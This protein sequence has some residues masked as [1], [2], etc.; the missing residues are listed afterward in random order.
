MPGRYQSP[1]LEDVAIRDSFWLPRLKT[2]YLVSLDHQ[3]DHL[4]ANGSLDNFRRVVGEAGGDFEGAPFIDANVYKWVEAASYALA[5]DE[6]P[7]LKTKVDNVLSLIEQAQADDGYLFT[8]FMLGDNSGRWS[9]FTMMHE[10]YCAGHLIEAAVAHHRALDDDR[11]LRVA[12]DL[13]DHIDERFG[14]D[15]LDKIPGH[16]EIELALVR[17]YRVTDEERYLHL[18]GYFID[19]RGRDPSPM[20][21]ELPELEQL[22]DRDSFSE[23]QKESGWSV[24]G[25]QD[26]LR[27]ESGAYDGLW[28][29]DHRPVRDQRRV[30]GHAVRAGNLYAA[31]A[32]YLQEV[33]DEDLFDAV[34]RL[35]QNMVTRRMYVTGGIGS[36]K[37]GERFTTDYDLPNDDAFAETC[38]SASAIFWSQNMFELT[39]E[40]KY[41]DVLERILYNALLSGVS[42]DGTRYCYSNPLQTDDEYHRNE[43]FYVA[44]CPPNLSRVLASLGKYVYARSESELRVNLYVSSTVETTVSGT[45]VT[46]E[47]STEYPWDGDVTVEL[48]PEE[49]TAFALG[50]RIPD[51]AD[52]W[53]L[54]V[55]GEPVAV[56][57][58]DGYATV[59]REWQDGDR[60]EIS[61]AMDPTAVVAHPE[62]ESDR[63]LAAL[64]RGPLVYCLEDI[65]NSQ[66]VH[67]LILSDPDSLSARYTD[68]V[69]DGMTI[70]EGEASVQD[71]EEWQDALYRP[72]QSVTESA[73]EFTAIPYYARNNR[74][75]TSMIVWMRLA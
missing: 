31:V 8:Y 49:P 2:N 44:C 63:A 21:A 66:P 72:M 45:D 35:W 74:G 43:W 46:V 16:E 37:F 23:E 14:P 70:L 67:H 69:L 28:A 52:R 7:T 12:R 57:P 1:A 32:A 64:R 42:L 4:Q 27:D 15:K 39:G 51:W 68:S 48:S 38:A 65:D 61:L 17:L 5:T 33:D 22:I 47:Q 18:A 62:V 10:L 36:Q 73:T 56:E 3:Y 41:V 34:E 54:A 60:I 58:T 19:R 6:M 9:N 20:A 40:G 30:E 59:E 24:V 26:T 55:D 75:Q 50:F 13:A 71:L 25:Y 11:L 29:Q 53:D